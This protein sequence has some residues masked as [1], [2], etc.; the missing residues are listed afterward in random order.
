MFN[1]N[2]ATREELASELRLLKDKYSQ[3]EQVYNP[4]KGDASKNYGHGFWQI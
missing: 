3:M 2:E 4:L 1:K